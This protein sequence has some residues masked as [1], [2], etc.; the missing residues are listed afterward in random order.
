MIKTLEEFSLSLGQSFIQKIAEKI[1]RRA[2]I[3]SLNITPEIELKDLHAWSDGDRMTVLLTARAE[4]G[5]DDILKL[6]KL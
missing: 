3:K 4:L 5:K 1:L 6:I 2:L